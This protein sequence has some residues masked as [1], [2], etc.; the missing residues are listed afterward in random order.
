MDGV[1][2]RA[3][4]QLAAALMKQARASIS[5]LI[6]HVLLLVV[7]VVR[8]PAIAMQGMHKYRTEQYVTR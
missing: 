6:L 2:S 3:A 4:G 7:L 8:T 1:R 5:A